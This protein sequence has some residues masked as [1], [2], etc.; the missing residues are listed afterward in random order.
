METQ[1]DKNRSR[2]TGKQRRTV[3]R[4][5]QKYCA[6]CFENHCLLLDD[7]ESTVCPQTLT[8][9]LGCG[10]FIRSVLPAKPRLYA[11]LFAEKKRGAEKR[12]VICGRTYTSLSNRSRY[13]GSCRRTVRREQKT[14]YENRKNGPLEAAETAKIRGCQRQF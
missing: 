1:A 5:I 13:C 12:C 14:A 11:D 9:R 4:L 10:Y 6:N 7:G 8:S 2:M 3:N